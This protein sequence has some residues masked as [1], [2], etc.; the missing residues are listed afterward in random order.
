MFLSMFLISEIVINY[1]LM[2]FFVFSF[3]IYVAYVGVTLCF[4]A[5]YFIVTK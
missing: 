1:M 5:H 3:K 2:L 4:S